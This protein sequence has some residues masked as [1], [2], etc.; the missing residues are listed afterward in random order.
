MRKKVI[1]SIWMAAVCSISA[2]AQLADGFYHFRNTVTGRY[3]S[4]NDTNPENYQINTHSGDMNMGGFRTYLN[5]DT[6]AVSPSC[7]LYVKKL[8]NG[9]YDVRGQGSGLYEITS[10]RYGVNITPQGGDTYKISGTYQGILKVLSDG[11]PSDKDSWLMNR[12]TET[13]NWKAIPVNTADEYIGISPDVKT[14]DGQYYGTIYAG[15][16]FRLVSPGMKAFYVSK[17]QGAGFTMEEYTQDIIPAA[18]PVII[19]CS[20][21]NPADNK[22]EPV[23]V[24]GTFGQTNCLEGVYCSLS[25]V[26]KHF[27]ATIYD[28]VTMR[29]IGLDDNGALA[30]VTAKPGQLYKDMYLKANKAFLR[31]GANSADIMTIG[32][33]TGIETVSKGDSS[34]GVLYSLS[35]VRLPS[36]ATPRPGIYILRTPNGTTR[37]VRKY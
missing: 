23:A 30:F 16:S 33:Y 4:I 29:V 37:K 22:I 26:S 20:S 5:Y 10:G 13:Q 15:F 12:L 14:A 34:D 21:A 27:N 17:A 3:V 2:S 7:I 8:S 19:R 9:Q 31:V 18:T 1:I 28:A 6:V 24:D 32:N 36:S 11:S 25:G 35:G